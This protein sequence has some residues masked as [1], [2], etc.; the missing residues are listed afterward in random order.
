MP[1]TDH[2][3]LIKLFRGAPE[4]LAEVMRAT[5]DLGLPAAKREPLEST[6]SDMAAEYRADLVLGFGADCVI[7]EV[8]LQKNAEKKKSWPHYVTSLH[9][10]E[11]GRVYL[12]VVTDSAEV[13]RWASEPIRLG[14]PGSVFIPLVLGPGTC[15]RIRSLKEAEQR[16]AL[17]VLSA[18]LHAGEG[19]DVHDFSA[20]FLGAMA[21]DG[22]RG[23]FYGD[24]VLNASGELEDQIL[25]AT[26]R[27][28]QGWEPKSKF[29][30]EQW[31]KGRAEG[32]AEATAEALIRL[33]EARGL[34]PSEEE[35]QVI[36]SSRDLATL[37][38]WFS[39]A[40]TNASAAQLLASKPKP[41]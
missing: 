34:A 28:S 5:F 24:W 21:L 31:S 8:Q 27:M 11:K 16:P 20:G 23:T 14:N 38:H 17:A 13:G 10:R 2:E 41:E 6:F 4:L 36:L 3:A 26:M 1:S 35:R 39:E 30:R 9:L 40:L 37:E 25:E 29:G 18:I 7:V 19:A 32:R 33:L 12:I 15:P 22:E